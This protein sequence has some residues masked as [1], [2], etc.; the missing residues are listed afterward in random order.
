VSTRVELAAGPYTAEFVPELGMAGCSL[1]HDGFELVALD[2]G[3]ERL[4]AGGATGIPLLAPWAN[5]LSRRRFDV[6]G[7]AV[8]LEGVPLHDDGHGLPIH[9]TMIGERRWAVVDAEPDRV[10]ARF[11]YDT[12]ELLLA[13]PFPHVLELDVSV[14]RD[15]LRVETALTAGQE[16]PVPVAFG[17]HPYFRLPGSAGDWRLE[18][19]ECTPLELDPR[20]IPT[21]HSAQ[22][23][24]GTVRL[25]ERA[26]DD[27]FALD[28]PSSVAVTGG[29]LR[30]EVRYGAGYPYAQVF[31]PAGADF[32]AI[33]PMTA[34]TDALT[35][36][37]CP[38]VEPGE[39]CRA[40][41]EVAVTIS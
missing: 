29:E 17:W 26:W 40:V 36:D 14:G 2:G 41:F 37:E 11:D 1:T 38:L 4:R 8:D 24:R 5:R 9:G 10:R 16:G 34:A 33:E 35:R 20:G 18:L 19:P 22:D 13:F 7:V 12:P 21:G 32:V 28:G 15:G 30:L 27:L 23:A 39:T 3:L 31:S 25:R 6:A